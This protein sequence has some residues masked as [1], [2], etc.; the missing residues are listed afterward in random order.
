V[1]EERIPEKSVLAKILRNAPLRKRLAISLL[2]FSGLRLET[3]GN[4][5]RKD[6]LKISD[7]P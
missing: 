4:A 2:A 7:F 1:E 5:E 3:L 6:G